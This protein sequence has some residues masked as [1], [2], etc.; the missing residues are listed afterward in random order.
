[1][2][3]MSY[4]AFIDGALNDH[5]N[6]HLDVKALAKASQY[7]V[8]AEIKERLRKEITNTFDRMNLV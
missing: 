5:E 3:K 8:A 6:W 7:V 4:T 2:E 1:M